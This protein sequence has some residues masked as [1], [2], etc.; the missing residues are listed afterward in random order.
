ML[1]NSR[2]FLRHS[3]ILVY[4]K[5][6]MFRRCNRVKWLL[7]R[8]YL[9]KSYLKDHQ[10]RKM[11]IGTGPSLLEGWLN[12]D[13]HPESSKVIFLDASKPFPFQNSLFSYIYCEHLIEHLKYKE[14][15][16]MLNECYRVLKPG[17]RIRIATPSLETLID[18]YSQNKN[19]LQE[20][21][22]KRIF[23]KF[24][25]EN[26]IYRE[27]IVINNAFRNYEHQFIYDRS[28]L[29]DSIEEAGF[30]EVTSCEYGESDDNNFQDVES[31]GKNIGDK[32]IDQFHTMILEAKRPI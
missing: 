13:I 11:Q 10:I 23:D 9:I 17:G 32:D 14:G 28:T 2:N 31:H 30:I 26:R 21:Y 27:A 15:L 5:R 8:P 22:M 6:Y 29:Q 24:F 16:S 18:L 12:T 7:I 3:K 1:N 4:I 19:D 20:R 25:P